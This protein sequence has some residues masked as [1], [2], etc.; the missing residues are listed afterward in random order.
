MIIRLGCPPAA[1]RNYGGLKKYFF[2]LPFK[3]IIQY[4]AGVFK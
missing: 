2:H 3:R 1:R 4:E